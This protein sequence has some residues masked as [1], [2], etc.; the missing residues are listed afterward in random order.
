MALIIFLIYLAIGFGLSMYTIFEDEDKD[1]LDNN[2]RVK[3]NKATGFIIFTTLAW[4]II[5]A[6]TLGEKIGA[7]IKPDED[8]AK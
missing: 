8:D 7:Y 6:T 3:W 4:G 2:G 5:M 1:Y